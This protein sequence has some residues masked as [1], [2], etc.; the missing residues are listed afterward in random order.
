VEKKLIVR[1][2]LFG[3]IV[4]LSLLTL[5]SAVSAVLPSE[6]TGTISPGSTSYLDVMFSSINSIPTIDLQMNKVYPG[7]S[8]YS[9]SAN[10]SGSHSFE[11]YSSLGALPDTIPKADWNKINYILNN[12]ETYDKNVIQAAI[13]HYTNSTVPSDFPS[14]DHTEYNRLVSAAEANGGDFIPIPQQKYAAVLFSPNTGNQEQNQLIIVELPVQSI[15]AP[16]FPSLALPVAMMLGIIGSVYF[17]K[18]RKE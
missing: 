11:V 1:T 6:A 10:K 17:V 12:K 4:I 15:P 16:E 14:Y 7:W 13:W 18:G 2:K 5:V 9:L 3:L 8:A